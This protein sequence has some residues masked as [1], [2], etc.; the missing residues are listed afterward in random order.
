MMM[1]LQMLLLHYLAFV[2]FYIIFAK[3]GIGIDSEIVYSTG[4]CCLKC[5]YLEY[6]FTMV[7]FMANSYQYS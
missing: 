5:I 3:N 2:T 6:I 1:Y 7:S 4:G